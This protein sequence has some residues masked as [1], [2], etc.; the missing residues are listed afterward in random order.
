VKARTGGEGSTSRQ[1]R[2]SIDYDHCANRHTLA[3]PRKAIRSIFESR[4]PGSVLD[5]GCGIG[6]W[7]KASRE[8]GVEDVF[9]ID[10]VDI[11]E[12]DLLFPI[13]RFRRLD[14]ALPWTLNRKF[15]VV[16]C[17]EV[18][19][20]LDETS[21]ALLIHSLTRHADEVVFSAACPGQ[22]G[23]NHVN[24][25]WPGYWQALFNA[26]GFTCSDAIRW[27]MWNDSEIDVWYRQNMFIAT[28]NALEAGKEA[29]LQAVVHPEFLDAFVSVGASV[30]VNRNMAAARQGALPF[31]WYVTSLFTA[32]RFKLRHRLTGGWA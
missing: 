26:Q 11:A 6:T 32:F 10:G 23:Q 17:L 5:V 8:L 9:G 1:T 16:L 22:P 13:E 18:A 4:V 21:S 2:H 25:Q 3:G 15:D 29:R 30:A 28:R 24:C 31:A 19:E 20:H 7:L 27:A 14:L 12:A